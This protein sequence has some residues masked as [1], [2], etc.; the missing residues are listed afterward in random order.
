MK[1]CVPVII[2]V[3]FSLIQITID[4][5]KGLYNTAG[6]KLLFST[7]VT[8]ILYVLCKKDLELISWVIVLIPF[9]FASVVTGIVLYKLNW[10]ATSGK[11]CSKLPHV[12]ATIINNPRYKHGYTHLYKYTTTPVHARFKM[13]Q[14]DPNCDLDESEL[15]DKKEEIKEKKKEKVVRESPVS[16]TK[17][18]TVVKDMY[19]GSS[20]PAYES[21]TFL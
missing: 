13:T 9:L 4:L 11:A 7:V 1:L 5:L 14:G 16:T 21:F 2:Y 15:F 10:K 18:K 17:P 12:D 8:I 19:F 20:E 3:M 6:I